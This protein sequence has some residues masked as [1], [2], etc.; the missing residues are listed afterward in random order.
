MAEE[1]E[2]PGGKK[3]KKEAEQTLTYQSN[4][5]GLTLR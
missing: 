2:Q 5:E 4:P 1:P 3:K